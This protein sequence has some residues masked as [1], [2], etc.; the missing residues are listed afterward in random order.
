MYIFW[1]LHQTTTLWL[2]LQNMRVVYLLIPTS[3]HNLPKRS[4]MSIQL[5]IF[6][7]LHQTTTGIEYL[8]STVCC[9][10]FDSYIKPQPGMLLPISCTVVYL[11]I[12]TSNHNLYYLNFANMT[13]YIFWFLHQTT[14]FWLWL[15]IE[16]CCISFDSYIKPQRKVR[17]IC[18]NIGCIS[19]D[20]YIKP[21]R[22]LAMVIFLSVVYLLIPT[23][24]HN[25]K[26]SRSCCYLLYIF[27]F[28]HQTT[29]KAWLWNIYDQLYIFWFLHQTTTSN[30]IVLKYIMLYIFWFLHQTTTYA[31]NSL[32]TECCISFDSY[33]KPQLPYT[34]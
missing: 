23:S 10:S 34:N 26:T 5:Y 20:S 7:F 17:L 28:L 1:F 15:I 13:L 19:F 18:L 32:W 3:N 11:L 29:T 22:Y 24:N 12:P 21:Q 6:W 9:I 33:I 2:I 30:N 27:W 16:T 8:P 25:W 4:P 14:T 31:A